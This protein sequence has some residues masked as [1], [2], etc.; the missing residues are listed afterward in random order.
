MVDARDSNGSAG[1]PTGRN[2]EPYEFTVLAQFDDGVVGDIS[3]VPG[4][5][6]S[7]APGSGKPVVVNA[8]GGIIVENFPSEEPVTATLPAPWGGA[9][10]TGRALGRAPWPELLPQPAATLVSG[11]GRDRMTEVPNVLFLPDGFRDTTE[12]REAFDGILAKL[13]DSLR[14]TSQGRPFDLF[15]NSDKSGY[16]DSINYWSVFLPSRE[17][18]CSVLSEVL[19]SDQPNG[20]ITA[21]PARLASSFVPTGRPLVLEEAIFQIGL[22]VVADIA[23]DV[24]YET[25]LAHWRT[26]RGAAQIP[27]GRIP[28]AV[29]NEWRELARRTLVNEQDTILGLGSGERPRIESRSVPRS[30]GIRRFRMQRQQLDLLLEKLTDGPG[31]AAI[32]TTWTTGKDRDFVFGLVGGAPNF[33]SQGSV[34]TAGLVASPL[35]RLTQATEAPK[36]VN[37]LPYDLPTGWPNG[38]RLP[39]RSVATVIHELSHAFGLQDEYGAN[40]SFFFLPSGRRGSLLRTGNVQPE[41]E[42]ETAAGT[43]NLDGQK[44]RWRYRRI[45]RAAVMTD[46]ARVISDGPPKRYV[47]SLRPGQKRFFEPG[48]TVFLRQRPLLQPPAAGQVRLAEVSGPLEVV[49]AGDQVLEQIVVN[50]TGG[51]LD[52]L[53]FVGTGFSAPIVFLPRAEQPNADNAEL[54]SRVIR[55]HITSTQRPLNRKAPATCSRD[56]N[57][58]QAPVNLPPNLRFP[59]T[60]WGFAIKSWVVGAFDGGVTSHCAVYHPAGECIMRGAVERGAGDMAIFCPVCR[61][62]LVDMVD[63][64]LHGPIDDAYEEIYPS[65]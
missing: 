12:D 53:H 52:P 56:D 10:A 38:F 22:P 31:G 24:T 40:D 55:E 20:S 23:A 18:G 51:T 59:N 37:Y 28:E 9:Q 62:L 58:V 3:E 33:G 54:V 39:Q 29:Y 45:L 26:I 41:S 43:G 34:I 13:I 4:I 19:R 17:R 65:L 50:D 21:E 61:Y 32:G 44:L 36:A 5:T 6:W 2:S 46:Q 42:L 60:F 35:I 7:P 8:A 27:D 48:Q 1:S 64:S 63:P 16:S 49:S 47:I 11:P 30:L 15:F 57:T 25:K 14:R